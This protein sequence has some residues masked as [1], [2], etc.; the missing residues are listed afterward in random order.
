VTIQCLEG[1]AH[2]L[3]E[4]PM[5]ETIAD[6][7]RM[8][9]TARA[10]NRMLCLVHSGRLDPVIVRGVDL[11]KSG[12]IGDVISMDFHRSSDYPA[13]PGGGRLPPQYRKGSYPFQDLGIHGMAI[14]EAFLGPV[15]S[16][17]VSF[18]STGR[19]TN[20]VFD[21]WEA[22]VHCEKGPARL[23]LSWNV[24][25]VRSQVIVHGTAGVMQIDCLLQTCYVTKLLP[26]PKF[27][28]PVICAV[29]NAAV[30]LVE[31]PL[32]V[33]RFITKKL[34]GAPGIHRNVQ[35]FYAALEQGAPAPVQPEEGLRLLRAML[36]ACDEA[37]RQREVMRAEQLAERP[38]A[39]ALVTGAGGFLGCWRGWL[40]TD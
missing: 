14:A 35:E 33:L 8:V 2:V 16:A 34:P 15:R 39:D 1:G 12:A 19:D 31:V 38:A 28:S 17:E 26:G 24:R 22:D 9:E 36:P 40:R 13:W 25:P 20:L 11:V 4:K 21:E 5:A 6:C 32:N 3:V 30:S 37:D 7:E 29:R 23:Y 10:N 27:A 18:R